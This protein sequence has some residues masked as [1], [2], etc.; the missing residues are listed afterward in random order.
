ML[1]L[2]VI[3]SILF[4]T[5]LVLTGLDRWSIAIHLDAGTRGRI[6]L[7]LVLVFTSIGHFIRTQ[8][9]VHMLPPAIPMREAIIYVS[10]ALEL[11]FA[12]GLLVRRF[13]YI[14]GVCIVAFLILV[15]PANIY[16]AVNRVEMGGHHLGPMYLLVRVPLQL[17]LAGWTYWFAIRRGRAP[18][19][20]IGH[21]VL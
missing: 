3:L 7:A 16:A 12:V 1:N 6:S 20:G 5:Y 15:L 18:L 9:M 19:R 21:P 8:A 13:A 17:I 11:F 2:V 10:G 14:A 4:G